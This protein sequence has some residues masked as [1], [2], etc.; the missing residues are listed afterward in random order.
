M[1]ILSQKISLPYD[2]SITLTNF[3]NTHFSILAK[4]PNIHTFY[5]IRHK[6]INQD[7]VFKLKTALFSIIKNNCFTNFIGIDYIEFHNINKTND[8]KKEVPNLIE[9]F[10]EQDWDEQV[11]KSIIPDNHAFCKLIFYFPTTNQFIGH[12]LTIPD[13]DEYSFG[14]SLSVSSDSAESPIA[15]HI[16]NETDKFSY[17]PLIENG[18]IDSIIV[19]C[20]VEKKASKGRKRKSSDEWL[21]DSFKNIKIDNR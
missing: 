16:I 18:S 8:Y 12:N 11:L 7:D 21:C 9:A 15:C 19:N 17:T 2:E 13:W 1:N 4:I 10:N 6:K 5:R 14:R 20:V 3:K